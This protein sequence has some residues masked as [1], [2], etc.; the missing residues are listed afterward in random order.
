MILTKNIEKIITQYN[1]RI[2][3]KY[4]Y[5]I[6]DL[7]TIEVNQLDN[8]SHEKIDVMC[9]VC[10]HLRDIPYRQ[11]LESFNKYGI[12]TCSSKCSQVKNKLTKKFRYEDENYNNREKFKN[13]CVEIY[14]VDNTFKDINIISKIDKIKRLKYGDNLELI[15][16]KMKKTCLEVYG[17]DNVSKLDYYK[18][19]KS[20]TTF[21]NYGVEY[22]SQSPELKEK[23]KQTCL[24]KYGF[25]YP[26][27]SNIIKDKIKRINLD[28]YGSEWFTNSILYKQKI[29]EKYGIDINFPIDLLNNWKKTE[30]YQN[31]KDE[32]YTKI[33]NSNI[34]SGYWFSSKSNEYESYR[35]TVMS[36]TSRY[37]KTL[38]EKWNGL[39][40]YDIEYIKNNFN[41]NY[42]DVSYPT[43]DHKI[44]IKYGFD[45]NINHEVIGGI[46]N[47]CIT[48][49]S[50]NSIKNKKTEDEY[51]KSF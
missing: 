37:K 5:K 21:K 39:D 20:E 51:R 2:F 46:D 11:Y 50:I 1:L 36:I 19:I 33:R 10:N 14:G 3:K 7:A 30:D 8:N 42:N 48:K 38:F 17:V 44:S 40:Y 24:T 23:S 49:R 25:E 32:I 6:G 26:I 35:K 31:R 18:K 9:D 27:Q 12:Y 29:K 4:G 13:T 22:P 28:R 47:L 41:L 16:S 15:V 45:N 34:L 43:I